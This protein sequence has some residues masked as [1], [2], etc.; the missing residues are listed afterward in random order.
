MLSNTLD[1]RVLTKEQ[2]VMRENYKQLKCPT[3]GEQL[4]YDASVGEFG[5]LLG[6]VGKMFTI[7]YIVCTVKF[8]RFGVFLWVLTNTC[9]RVTVTT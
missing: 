5:K 4:Q 6:D 7:Q 1:V 3:L 2:L 9:R 8:T